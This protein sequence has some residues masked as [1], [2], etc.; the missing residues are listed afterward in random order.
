M[1]DVLPRDISTPSDPPELD[2]R[3]LAA[4]EPM[5]RALIAAEALAAGERA[6]VLT[7][8]LP[9]PLLEALAGRGLSYRVE[10]LPT[11]GA[12][13]LIERPADDAAD[14]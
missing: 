9:L 4:P 2:L 13:V 10:M 5:R 3:R 6:C 14:D 11:G 7:P 12:R 1:H 8:L